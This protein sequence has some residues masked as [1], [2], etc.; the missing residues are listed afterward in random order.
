MVQGYARRGRLAPHPDRD[1]HGYPRYRLG[2]VRD[3]VHAQHAEE[4]E[5]TLRAAIRTAELAEKRRQKAARQ[6][7]KEQEMMSA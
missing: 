2:S 6:A 3:L 1:A 4:R 7:A 5:R